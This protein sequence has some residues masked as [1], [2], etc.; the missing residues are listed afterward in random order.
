MN[1]QNRYFGEVNSHL[2]LPD[3]LKSEVLEELAAHVADTIA[4]LQDAGL[5]PET[6]ESEAISRLGPP[7]ELARA[8][9]AARRTPRQLLAA[10]GS[11]TWAAIG[12]GIKGA[13][14]GW[15]IVA[16]ASAFV[17]AVAHQFRGWSAGWNTVLTAMVLA[18]GAF[19]A[20]T[21]ATRTVA[22]R[23][24]RA[25]PEVRNGVA[26][27]G[28]GVLAFLVLGLFETSLNWASV[29][30]LAIV[31]LAFAAG[32]RTGD[33][34]PGIRT[35]VVLFVAAAILTAG[36][37]FATQLSRGRID[38]YSWNEDTFGA[39]ILPL[40]WG[41]SST[42]ADALL[43][44]SVSTSQMV[45]TE[46]IE[47]QVPS[48]QVIARLTDFRLEAWVADAPRDDW[49]L[50]PGQTAPY[51]V[52]PAYVDGTSMSGTIVFN[53]EPL[54]NWAAVVLT[55]VGPDGRRYVLA[56]TGPEQTE[57]FGTV[58]NWIAALTR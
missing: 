30:G 19:A 6:A 52:A 25:A 8:L 55:A 26:L 14:T 7:S 48:P 40:W 4:D 21:A 20:G 44:G 39:G 50:A 23:A 24:W 38:S 35:A 28:A 5:G 27:A 34:R 1:A 11:G 12:S 31:P 17:W 42:A 32:T 49:H 3:E 18:T 36:A 33:V 16:I 43:Q 2:T 54:A 45:G 57:F 53:Q 56:A 9:V 29:L 58:W 46:A 51:A 15:L 47:Y 13:I 37:A 10:A 22:R 41:G